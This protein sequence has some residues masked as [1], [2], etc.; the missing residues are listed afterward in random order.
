MKAWLQD[1]QERI[2]EAARTKD[3]PAYLAAASALARQIETRLPAFLR[4]QAL[5]RQT[6]TALLEAGSGQRA[7][8]LGRLAAQAGQLGRELMA[9]HFAAAR[10]SL[11]GSMWRQGEQAR[12]LFDGAAS[13][14]FDAPWPNAPDR[15]MRDLST[16]HEGQELELRGV[17]QRVEV[18][19]PEPGKLVGLVELLDPSSGASVWAA[20]PFCHMPHIGLVPGSFCEVQGRYELTS[21][22]R[23][24]QPTLQVRRLALA[25]L[26]Q[27]S[28]RAAFLRS[29]RDGYELYRNGLQMSWSLAPQRGDLDQQGA[30][31]LIFPPFWRRLGRKGA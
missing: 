28:W 16:G 23:Q 17:V 24:G 3:L 25:E 9:S 5:L 29:A 18:H 26:A 1:A 2:Y 15:Q 21:S 6:L 13:Q 19:H 22:L 20:A 4:A 11:Q 8:S 31:D 14:P 30:S 12:S 7:E 27:R 10:I